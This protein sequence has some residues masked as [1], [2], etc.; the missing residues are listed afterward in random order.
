MNRRHRGRRVHWMLRVSNVDGENMLARAEQPGKHALE[1][2]WASQ[3]RS[4]PAVSLVTT[5]RS[6]CRSPTF[7][8]G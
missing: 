1:D 2:K 7:A 3:P 8:N 5:A 4:F 6:L